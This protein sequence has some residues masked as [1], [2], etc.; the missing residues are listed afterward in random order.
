[1]AEPNKRIYELA[2]EY[3]ISSNAMLTILKELQFQPKSH[4][5]VASIEMIE[6][7]KR[8]FTEEKL[9]AKKEMDHRAHVKEATARSAAS[10]DRS[11]T[12]TTNVGDVTVSNPASPVAKEIRRIDRKQKR[13]DR[14]KKRG[15]QSVDRTEVA[16]SF[17][18]TMADLSGGKPKRRYRKGGEND[19]SAAETHE[20]VLDV[21]EYMSL[22]ELAKLMDRK[23]A[24]VIAKL[25]ELGM[26]ATINQRLDIDSIGMVAEEFGFGITE[27]AE[28]GEE[29]IEVEQE[30]HLTTRAPI[31]TVMGH[32]DHGKTSLLDF[33]RETNVTAGEAGAITQHIGAYVVNHANGAITFLDTP[34]H[35]AF[36][37]MRARGSQITDIV[38]L[39]VA[40]DDGVQPQTVE[41]IDHARAAGAPII[42]AINKI[43]KPAANVDQV[44]TQLASHN[45]SPEDWGGKTIMV[46]VSAKSGEGVERLLE[47]I[48][49]QAEMMDLQADSTIRATGVVVD[50]RLEKGRGPVVTVLVQ[51][52]TCG[53]GAPIVSGVSCGRVRTLTDDRNRSLERVG[54]STPVQVRRRK[55]P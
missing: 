20:N 16:K 29:S 7:V 3:K 12:S 5:S 23:P 15:R 11:K 37:A 47:M 42:V 48:L 44:R 14:R 25:F 27:V 19:G 54:P 50:S 41:A 33:I 34:G 55:S 2:R 30:D 9:E 49:L 17:K 8:K 6:A 1:M 53:I 21:T 38:V 32:V 35:E 46:P 45:L 26:M 39:V 13:K 36:T 4:M 40:A 31:V 28:I 51:K 10:A 43:D 18:A 52:G 22:S 24:E